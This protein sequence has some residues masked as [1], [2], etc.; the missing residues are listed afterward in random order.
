M[1][2]KGGSNEMEN[3]NVPDVLKRLR[4][5]NYVPRT[6]ELKKYCEEA[7]EPDA[8]LQQIVEEQQALIRSSNRKFVDPALDLD[9]IVPRKGNW[10]MKKSLAPKLQRLEQRTKRA[11]VEILREK[12]A[13]KGKLLSQPGDLRSLS[14]DDG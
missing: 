1:R 12:Q 6:E 2:E 13:D 4:F 10:D 8:V 3:K 7:E 5:Q 14:S 9:N 11:L